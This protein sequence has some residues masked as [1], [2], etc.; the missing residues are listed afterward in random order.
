MKKVLRNFNVEKSVSLNS[1]ITSAVIS[2]FR[3]EYDGK[4][5]LND[6]MDK[7]TEDFEKTG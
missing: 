3:K 2:A 6:D 4:R 7:L 5:L 1:V